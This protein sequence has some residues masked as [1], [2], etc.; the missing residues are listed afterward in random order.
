[1]LVCGVCWIRAEVQ[2]LWVATERA[3]ALAATASLGAAD[4]WSPATSSAPP[5]VPLWRMTATAPVRAG[6]PVG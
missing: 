2:A 4:V 5:V 1:M 6:W 3:G